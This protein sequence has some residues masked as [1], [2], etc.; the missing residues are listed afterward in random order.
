M[1]VKIGKFFDDFRI[2]GEEFMTLEDEFNQHLHQIGEAT[3]KY[4]YNPTYFLRMLEEYGG[5]ETAKRLLKKSESQQGLFTLWELGILHE[6]VEAA[7][8]SEKYQ[9]LFSKDELAEAH[10]RLEELGFFNK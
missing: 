2:F 6:S 1:V 3:K 5:I 10:R 4:N 7:V 9:S 8:I